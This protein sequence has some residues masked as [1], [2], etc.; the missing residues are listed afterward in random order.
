[1]VRRL[2]GAGFAASLLTL[3]IP[4]VVGA[5]EALHQAAP[6]VTEAYGGHGTDAGRHTTDLCERYEIQ[7]GAHRAAEVYLERGQ[8]TLGRAVSVTGTLYCA[9]VRDVWPLTTGPGHAFSISCPS[10]E[11]PISGGAG[12]STWSV[13]ANLK[14]VSGSH[15]H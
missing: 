10:D 15:G 13:S 8:W 5:Q 14:R 2:L 6:V 3:G 9:P 7:P 1:M 11:R 12:Y 4:A